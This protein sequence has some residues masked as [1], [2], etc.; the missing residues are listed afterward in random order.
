MGATRVLPLLLLLGCVPGLGPFRLPEVQGQ[1]LEAG[2]QAPVVGALVLEWHRGAGPGGAS[3]PVYHA[4]WTTTD[5]DGAFHLPAAASPS[6]RMWLLKTYA[7][8]YAF[9]HPDFGL[10]RGAGSRGE[11]LVMRASRERAEQGFA[12]LR[13]YCNGEIDDAGARRLAEVACAQ[14]VRRPQG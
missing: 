1:V 10:Q 7:P 14:R 4:R 8:S 11:P 2:S 3:Q 6:P 13:P 9:F 12:D 5:V